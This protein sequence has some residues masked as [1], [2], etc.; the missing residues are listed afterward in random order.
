[1][2]RDA[3]FL[4]VSRTTVFLLRRQTSTLASLLPGLNLSPCTLTFSLQLVIASTKLSNGL[5]S[6]ELLEGPFLDVLGL[7]LLELC[8][9]LNGTLQ[10]RAL[11]LFASMNNLG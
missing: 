1:M 9:K 10:D 2:T 5:F 11:V 4:V 8:D 3:T 6:Q 7:V